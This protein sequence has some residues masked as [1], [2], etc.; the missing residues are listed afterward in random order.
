MATRRQ[1]LKRENT[2]ESETATVVTDSGQRKQNRK[3]RVPL[4]SYRTK[5]GVPETAL[6]QTHHLHWFNDRGGRLEA[7]EGAGYEYVTYEELGTATVGDR[8]VESDS[9]EIGN[10]VNKRVGTDEHGAPVIAYLM[11]QKLEWYNED[12]QAKADEIDRME[13]SIIDLEGQDV[14]FRKHSYGKISVES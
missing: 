4:G 6:N 5:M 12:Q 1:N 9:S 13:Q 11:K 7:A 10:R 2:R 3:Q 14:D 8:N